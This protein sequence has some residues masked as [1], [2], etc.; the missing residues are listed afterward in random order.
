M[1]DMIGTVIDVPFETT[2]N[3]DTILNDIVTIGVGSKNLVN[4]G[5]IRDGGLT[6]VYQKTNTTSN[7]SNSL[8]Y[9]TSSGKRFYVDDDAKQAYIDDKKIQWDF[10]N[11]WFSKGVNLG[12]FDDAVLSTTGTII[13]LLRKRY[14]ALMYEYDYNGNLLNSSSYTLPLLKYNET[15]PSCI[16]RYF[17]GN[18]FSNS[19][20]ITEVCY[21]SGIGIGFHINLSTMT[22]YN[23]GIG[24]GTSGGDSRLYSYFDSTSTKSLFLL[25][26][27]ALLGSPGVVY[28]NTSIGGATS[29]MI[30][31]GA[32]VN[33]TEYIVPSANGYIF[34]QKNYNGA[35]FKVQTTNAAWG[36]FTE[37]LP[38]GIT[39][40]VPR[41]T[42][43]G[44]II[45][46]INQFGGV[47]H[48]RGTGITDALVCTSIFTATAPEKLVNIGS[49]V[50]MFTPDTS[51][52]A[53]YM[54]L[55]S[56]KRIT[57]SNISGNPAY[58]SLCGAGCNM[59][60]EYGAIDPWHVPFSKNISGNNFRFM[61]RD[62]IGNIRTVNIG[63]ISF[64]NP[65][66]SEIDMDVLYLPIS[67]NYNIFESKNNEFYVNYGAYS[68]SH[69]FNPKTITGTGSI[70]ANLF[71]SNKFSSMIDQGKLWTGLSTSIGST[72][73]SLMKD[74][75]KF[76]YYEDNVGYNAISLDQYFYFQISS[77][78]PPINYVQSYFNP[79]PTGYNYDY[80]NGLVLLDD[81]CAP[82]K[83]GMAS[84]VNTNFLTQIYKS[85]FRLFG[86]LYAYDG[87]YIYNLPLSAGSD[88][89][90]G[91][92]VIVAYANGLTFLC[93][94]PKMAI[95]L[96]EFDNS[97]YVFNG[98]KD[99]DRLLN[100]NLKPTVREAAYCVASDELAIKCC[101][102]STLGDTDGILMM[103]NGMISEYLIK[104]LIESIGPTTYY[105]DIPGDVYIKVD[106]INY[107]TP[108]IGTGE[109]ITIN[110]GITYTI[111][112]TWDST[113]HHLQAAANETWIV[114][115]FTGQS[116]ALFYK[117]A[118]GSVI[119]PLKLQ[120]AYYGMGSNRRMRCNRIVY[121]VKFF[122][123][124]PIRINFTWD[125]IT[126]GD[127]T[128]VTGTDSASIIPVTDD[129]GCAI[130]DWIP[131]V[132][133]V[134]GG[135]IGVS[136]DDQEQKFMILSITIY[137]A[138]EADCQTVNHAG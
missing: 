138:I 114:N 132:A 30:V 35:P 112:G 87:T 119:V 105:G 99:V 83:P 58:Y 117:Q 5:I 11:A 74:T 84:Y 10:T 81:G 29:G 136:V 90:V 75:N 32:G 101:E 40:P 89:T 7:T 129:Q 93:Q 4:N 28:Y 121:R 61:Y 2:L 80:R 47:A 15:A 124:I 20:Y 102:N 26:N 57:C 100:L 107:N 21:S 103:R 54:P 94:T 73:Y 79:I 24:V 60:T 6:E 44:S 96:S 111:S 134:I 118:T 125:Y 39:S 33:G 72:F 13:C 45:S 115:N 25:L 41:T 27:T 110:S 109:T 95:F 62:S 55:D 120:T 53:S 127:N 104:D 78:I 16:T 108:I 19:I 65:I 49:S 8:T 59:I 66:I 50:F 128:N 135:S 123:K 71:A 48:Y 91:T 12:Y 88:G 133:A 82:G 17:T 92:P 38:A 76:F 67:D 116:I 9:Y 18:T 77:A 1:E 137:T 56:V 85:S 69:V 98:G 97:L 130:I 131:P 42:G 122:D 126:S 86:Q 31:G 70:S 36:T 68:T 51:S 43:G 46:N 106:T 64:V 34:L 22:T 37:I 52:Y 14:S 113:S 63:D 3:T 23:L